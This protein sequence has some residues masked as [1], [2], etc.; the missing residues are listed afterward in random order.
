MRKTNSVNVR[1][2]FQDRKTERPAELKIER[3]GAS[4]DRPK[5]LIPETLDRLQGAA[6]VKRT[7]KL[8]AIIESFTHD[9]QLPPADQAYCQLI[10][11]DPNIYYFHSAWSSQMTKFL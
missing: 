3:I 5:P 4:E 1:Q 6:T 7:A 8:F 10:G 9:N 2:T 11:G